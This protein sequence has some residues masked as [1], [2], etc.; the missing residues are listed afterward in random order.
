MVDCGSSAFKTPFAHTESPVTPQK[1]GL[2]EKTSRKSLI[3]AAKSQSSSHL[4]KEDIQLSIKNE[5]ADNRMIQTVVVTHT[6]KDHYSWVNEVIKKMNF[7][8]LILGGAPEKY[9]NTSNEI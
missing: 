7:G 5:L 8:S 1:G 2:T 4:G 6:D 3:I 9:L